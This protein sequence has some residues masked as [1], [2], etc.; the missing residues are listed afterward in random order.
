[1]FLEEIISE[2][3]RKRSSSPKLKWSKEKEGFHKTAQGLDKQLY[4]WHTTT[5]NYW[6]VEP[7]GADTFGGYTQK[8]GITPNWQVF[9]N[10]A[11]LGKP[12]KTIAKAKKAVED[13]VNRYE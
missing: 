11:K 4:S 5:N 13:W 6:S 3:R 12:H 10:G 7:T 2:A 9:K 1:M 8:T